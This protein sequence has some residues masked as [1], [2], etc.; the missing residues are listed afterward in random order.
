MSTIFA[1]KKENTELDVNNENSYVEVA[2]RTRHIYWKNELAYLLP[3]KTKVIPIDNTAQG[4]ETIGDIIDNIK[5]QK[6]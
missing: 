1:V 3:R 4:I 5:E 2:F 6:G